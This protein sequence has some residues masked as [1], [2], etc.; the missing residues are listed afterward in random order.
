MK[1]GQ[2]P[3]SRLR[4]LL[5]S[6][7]FALL[8]GVIAPIGCFYLKPVLL[9]DFM[10]LPGLHFLSVFW[11][12]GYGFMGL[13]MAA[14]LVWLDWGD[15][16]GSTS[17]FLSGVLEVGAWF[18]VGLGVVLL[19]FSVLGLLAGIGALGFVPFLTGF[20]YYRQSVIARKRADAL[21]PHRKL[22]RASFLGA[23]LVVGV[24]AAAQ[25]QVSLTVRFAIRDLAAGNPAAMARLRVWYRF[26]HRDRL[27]W[28]YQQEKNAT[29]KARLAAAYHEL[30]GDDVERRMAALRFD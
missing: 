3:R 25:T 11:V 29:R 12:F 5:D 13:E 30:T 8:A 1:P 21:M 7:V 20:V 16:T 14:L 19:P 18:A 28:A 15:R 23:I 2:T 26:A 9:G 4:S 27:V 6:A 24:P 22:Y 10:E 17:A